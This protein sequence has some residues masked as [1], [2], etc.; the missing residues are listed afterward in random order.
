MDPVSVNLEFISE[1]GRGMGNFL[2]SVASGDESRITSVSQK[3]L[4]VTRLFGSI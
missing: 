3:N 4:S 1:T 2:F